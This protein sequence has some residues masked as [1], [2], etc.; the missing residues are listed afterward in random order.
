L[1]AEA[2]PTARYFPP[3][4]IRD[5]DGPEPPAVPVAERLDY[6][7]YMTFKTEWQP[8][9]RKRDADGWWSL[10]YPGRPDVRFRMGRVWPAD[11]TR[12][13]RI[14]CLEIDFGCRP[15]HKEDFA[16]ARRLYRLLGK[17]AT[18][19]RQVYVSYPGYQ[20]LTSYEK[21]GFGAVWL[22]HDA[23]RWAREDPKRLLTMHPSGRGGHRPMEA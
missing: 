10:I 15:D 23:I 18:N 8:A 7:I 5:L 9:W 21:G 4:M 22:G 1:L 17:V 19:H 11:N 2:F 6:E 13:E 3:P 12:P 14:D 16:L 20:V